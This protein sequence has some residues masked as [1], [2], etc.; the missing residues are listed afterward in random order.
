LAL[1]HSPLAQWPEKTASTWLP[2]QRR[3]GIAAPQ[4]GEMNMAGALDGTTQ[5]DVHFFEEKSRQRA[6][7]K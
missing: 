6:L 3:S 7:F 1:L 5:L 2:Q 4:L